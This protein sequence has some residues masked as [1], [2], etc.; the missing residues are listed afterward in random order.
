[1]KPSRRDIKTIQDALEAEGKP[2]GFG[3]VIVPEDFFQRLNAKLNERQGPGIIEQLLQ[4]G[5]KA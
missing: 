4:T 5:E 3:G 1:M 2:D